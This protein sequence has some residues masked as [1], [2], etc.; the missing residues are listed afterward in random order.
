MRG[1]WRL[2][3]YIDRLAWTMGY[4]WFFEGCFG[5]VEV[6]LICRRTWLFLIGSVQQLSLCSLLLFFCWNFTGSDFE[7]WNEKCVYS[8]DIKQ[9]FYYKTAWMGFCNHTHT[10]WGLKSLFQLCE[11]FVCAYTAGQQFFSPYLISEPLFFT[12]PFSSSKM[13]LKAKLKYVLFLFFW[14]KHQLII[15]VFL[16]C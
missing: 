8:F 9:L 12:T 14:S 2:D 7:G 15:S 1:R 16:A 10:V 13:A 3:W 11:D 5:A 4:F 6:I